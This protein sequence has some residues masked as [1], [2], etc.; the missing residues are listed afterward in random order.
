MGTPKRAH[1]V[2][3]KL[4]RNGGSQAVRIPKEYRFEG[5]EVL[6]RQ[7]G[8]RVV[9]EPVDEWSEEFLACLG[10]LDEEIPRPK[11]ELLKD[12]RNPFK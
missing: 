6:I 7:E 1:P 3:A 10:S 5:S 9:I 2:R 11:Q 4:F 12:V 8:K